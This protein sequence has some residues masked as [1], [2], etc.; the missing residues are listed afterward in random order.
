MDFTQYAVAEKGGIQT[1]SSIHV[2]FVYDETVL[3]FVLRIGGLPLWNS[4][5]T[6]FKGTNTQSPYVVLATRS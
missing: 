4:A 3:R 5:L 1:D 2:N 6:P